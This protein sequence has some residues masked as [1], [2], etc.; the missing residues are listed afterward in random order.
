MV[1]TFKLFSVTAVKTLAFKIGFSYLRSVPTNN[2]TS[3]SSI[4]VILEF[5]I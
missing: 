2:K 3:A 5:M 4:P 1:K